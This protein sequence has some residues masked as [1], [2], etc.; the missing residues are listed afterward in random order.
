M[1]LERIIMDKIKQGEDEEREN[2][3]EKKRD[4]DFSEDLNKTKKKISYLPVPNH[5]EDELTQQKR[6]RDQIKTNIARSRSQTMLLRIAAL[7]GDS[8]SYGK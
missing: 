5:R 3:I 7:V 2:I 1:M 6:M 4:L 8:K